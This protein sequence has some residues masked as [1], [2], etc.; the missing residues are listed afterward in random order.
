LGP[1][2]LRVIAHFNPMYYIVEASRILAG[3][4]IGSNTVLIAF[5]VMLP[6]TAITL[7]WATNVYRK[8]LS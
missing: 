3:G 4:T 6:L 5:V 8:A 1:E 7:S 2:W